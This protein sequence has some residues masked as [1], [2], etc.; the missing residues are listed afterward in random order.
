MNCKYCNTELHPAADR[1]WKCGRALTVAA[2]ENDKQ[3]AL[4][5]LDPAM[6]KSLNDLAEAHLL[7][8]GRE[9]HFSEEQRALLDPLA[10]EVRLA[11]VQAAQQV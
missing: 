3:V 1:C 9:T 5:A 2:E 11:E 8:K 10:Q 4:M 6:N 7:R